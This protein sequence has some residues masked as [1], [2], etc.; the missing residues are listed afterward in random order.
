MKFT[1]SWLKH[2]LDTKDSLENI[3]S[4]LTMIGLEV[5]G[6]IDRRL[7]LQNFEVVQILENKI[8][9]MCAIKRVTSNKGGGTPGVD[10]EIWKE[11]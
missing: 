11:P 5:E 1:L 10:G 4:R 3:V 2:F 8:L 9:R 6:V 7:E